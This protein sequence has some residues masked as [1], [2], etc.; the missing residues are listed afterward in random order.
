M[1][2]ENL[3]WV[4]AAGISGWLMATGFQ[5]TT[6][7]VG[8]VDVGKVFNDSDY[9][10]SQ[11]ATLQGTV[12]ARTAMLEFVKANRLF[13]DKQAAAFR[14]LSVKP[15]LTP[16][17]KT[18]L[19]K[20]K[21]DVVAADKEFRDLQTKKTPTADDIK[22]M[23]DYNVEAQGMAA[24]SMRWAQSFDQEIRDLNEKWRNEGIDRVRDAVK[25]VGTKQ[26]FT[27]VYSND[28]APYGAIDVSDDVLKAMN[29]KK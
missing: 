22:K 3:G 27:I 19:E 15:A 11:S 20:I 7:K 8:V 13:T 14:D 18:Q 23:N 24:T 9:V 12:D 4:V 21:A 25:A 5:A 26:S 17:E 6:T 2:L 16:D 1:K 10:K 28:I 29:S